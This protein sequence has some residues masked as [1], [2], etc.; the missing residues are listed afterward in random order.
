MKISSRSIMNRF[1]FCL[2]HALLAAAATIPPHNGTYGV[3]LNTV[4]LTD[5]SRLDPFAPI[6]E[7]RSVM[8]SLFYPVAPINCCQVQLVEYMPV[9][10]AAIEDQSYSSYGVP[11]GT[12]ESLNLSLCSPSSR[13]TPSENFPVVLF[14]PG[15]GNSRLLYNAIAQS[16]ASHGFIVVTMDHPYDADVVEYPD[17]TLISAANISTDAQIILDVETRAK[18][19]SFVLDTLSNASAVGHLIPSLQTALNTKRAA[20]FGHSLGG[21]TAATAMMNDS[22]IVV[23][24]NLD[25]TFFGS[26]IENGV[27]DPLLLFGH[28]GKNQSTDPTW[29]EIWLHLGHGRLELMLNGAQHGTF[30]DFPLLLEVLGMTN[31][32]PGVADLIGTLSGPR[33]LEVITAHVV[34]FFHSVLERR[35]SP[36]LEGPSPKFP[37]NEIIAQ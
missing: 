22:R 25:G 15:L 20:M 5:T 31:E 29:G 13:S 24:A 36:L 33:A 2:L 35:E 10:T 17:G 26:V 16:V 28:E 32:L 21:A 1:L 23:G 34:A 18:D 30:T 14:S 27:C 6:P 3:N 11:N 8:I 4:K 19:A 9:A 37:E 7:N 12:F